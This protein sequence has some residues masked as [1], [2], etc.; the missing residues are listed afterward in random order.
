MPYPCLAISLH[1]GGD[2]AVN[3]GLLGHGTGINHSI[4]K[5][6]S[7]LLEG[8]QVLLVACGSWHSA[9]VT[10][11]GK[12]FTFGDGAFGALGHGDHES[13]FYPREVKCL[14]KLMTFKVACGMY[15]TAAIIEVTDQL[16]VNVI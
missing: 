11:N 6:I 8:L 5:Q 1:G 13:V 7:G 10:S 14:N 4:H 3:A 15:P 16:G 9:L 12:L 2:G